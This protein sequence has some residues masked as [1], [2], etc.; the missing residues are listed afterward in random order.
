MTRKPRDSIRKQLK[1][2]APGR[3]GRVSGMLSAAAGQ[4]DRAS[5]FLARL[6]THLPIISDRP[7]RCAFLDRQLEGWERR[8]ARFIATDGASEPAADPTDPPQAADFL[9]TIVGLAARRIALAR[10]ER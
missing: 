10:N 3:L 6:D 5:R 9:L 8:Y 1:D 7:A 2:T 4:S